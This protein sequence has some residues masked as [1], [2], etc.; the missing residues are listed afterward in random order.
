MWPDPASTQELL[1]Q[2]RRGNAD[3]VEELLGRHRE[4]LRRVIDLRLDP[5][6]RGRVDASDVV[7][8]VLL[9]A[10]RRIN[11]YLRDPVL[12]FHL[13]LRQMA[14]DRLIDAHRK[15]RQAQRRSLDREQ[16]LV[17]A[18]FADHSSLELAAQLLDQELTP[19]SQV[20]RDELHR[21]LHEAIASLDEDDQEVILMRHVEQLSNQE[22]AS[23]LGL[24]EP[25]ASMRYLRALRR[26]RALLEPRPEEP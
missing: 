2:A 17:P 24:T 15:H 8:E 6:I 5:A 9:E 1:G 14:R 10:S 22:V 7:Q 23:L 18:A 16:P 25:A 20:I 12:P 13:W 11:D 26:L 4:S 21:R 19:A 3:A